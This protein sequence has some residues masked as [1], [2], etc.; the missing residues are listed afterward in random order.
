MEHTISKMCEVLG[1]STS[2]YYAYVKRLDL[3]ETEREAF[4]RY[5]DERILFH[6]HDNL[7]AYG[8]PRIW[9]KL[10]DEDNITVSQKR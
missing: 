9:R 1:V 10:V 3:G 6:F 2:G 4:N 5:L 8:S 7:G